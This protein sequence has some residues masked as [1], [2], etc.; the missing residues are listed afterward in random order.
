MEKKKKLNKKQWRYI[1]ASGVQT[2]NGAQI[3]DSESGKWPPFF[4]PSSKNLIQLF[5][6]FLTCHLLNSCL[7]FFLSFELS[8]G[9]FSS[10]LNVMPNLELS[11]NE[12][13]GIGMERNAHCRGVSLDDL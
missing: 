12:W 8:L 7:V 5:L 4:M 2:R 13:K 11:S 10:F 1:K 3:S 9:C 6:P